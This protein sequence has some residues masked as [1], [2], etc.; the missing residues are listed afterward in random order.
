M[1]VSIP[2]PHKVLKVFILALL[3]SLSG[4]ARAEGSEVRTTWRLLDYIAVDYSAAVSNGQVID[5]F[6]YDEMV[7][8]SSTVGEQ[9]A[10]L[11]DASAKPGLIAMSV[12]L[13]Q[14]I[15]KK[16]SVERVSRLARAL[17]GSLSGSACK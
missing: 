4:M 12:D 8:F 1:P 11:P 10:A 3:L 9:V 17:G 6:E 16:A 5:N 13:R 14:A 7:E 2:S 15:E